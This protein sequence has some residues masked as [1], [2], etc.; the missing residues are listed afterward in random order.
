MQT[1]T[2]FSLVAESLDESKHELKT[3]HNVKLALP[4]SIV[5]DSL[6][7]KHDCSS[8]TDLEPQEKKKE[9]MNDIE[10]VA[11]SLDVNDNSHVTIDESRDCEEKR[12]KEDEQSGTSWLHLKH[13]LKSSETRVNDRDITCELEVPQPVEIENPSNVAATDEQDSAADTADLWKNLHVPAG[14]LCSRLPRKV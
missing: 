10:N 4:D 5:A 12:Q 6:E 11:D 7:V 1:E 2:S 3:S 9:L 14:F 8:E 13:D